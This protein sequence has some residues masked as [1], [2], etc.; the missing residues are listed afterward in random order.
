MNRELRDE[1][2]GLVAVRDDVEAGAREH[3][4]QRFL[5]AVAELRTG[6]RMNTAAPLPVECPSIVNRTEHERES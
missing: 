1:L 3:D 4:I 2:V 6:N 5:E